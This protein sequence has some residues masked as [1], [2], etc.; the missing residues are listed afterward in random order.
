M[1]NA[2]GRDSAKPLKERIRKEQAL[3]HVNTEDGKWRATDNSRR[4][5]M[6]FQR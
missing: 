3:E 2:H 6:T 5:K 1:S 4:D